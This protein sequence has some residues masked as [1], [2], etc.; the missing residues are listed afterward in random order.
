[1]PTLSVISSKR[2]RA[3]LPLA[4][5]WLSP[6]AKREWRRVAPALVDRRAAD[7]EVLASLEVYCA[8]VALVRQYLATLEAEG[9]IIE[10]PQGR[11]THPVFK[12]LMGAMRE[13]RLLAIELCLLPSRRGQ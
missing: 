3:A 7:P 10:S 11:K 9:H 8:A 13:V 1:M 4:P 12:Q 6:E 5:M 2:D